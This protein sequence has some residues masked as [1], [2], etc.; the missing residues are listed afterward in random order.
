LGIYSSGIVR[1]IDN[2]G[3]IVVPKEI[4]RKMNVREGDP[5]EIFIDESGKIILKSYSPIGQF[6]EFAEQYAETIAESLGQT[7]AI[8]DNHEIIAVLGTSFNKNMRKDKLLP[9]FENLIMGH[10]LKIENIGKISEDQPDDLFAKVMMPILSN[11]YGTIGSVVFLSSDS[12]TN[13]GDLEV[14]LIKVCADFLGR[15]YDA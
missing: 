13:I 10:E 11:D 9:E 7:V 6:S 5:V 2:L 4:R 3:R 15:Q 1:R 14:K 8:T 12:N